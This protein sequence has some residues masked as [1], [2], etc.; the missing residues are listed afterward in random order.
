MWKGLGAPIEHTAI[1]Y[2]TACLGF[3]PCYLAIPICGLIC[4][5]MNGKP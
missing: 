1:I 5:Y 4:Y 2:I 3:W